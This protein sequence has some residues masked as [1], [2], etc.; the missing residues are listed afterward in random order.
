M[1]IWKKIS[2][3]FT[4]LTIRTEMEKAFVTTEY[5]LEEMS[6]SSWIAEYGENI[7]ESIL[8]NLSVSR[9]NILHNTTQ[10]PLYDNRGNYT[11]MER[12]QITEYIYWY[13][14][15]NEHLIKRLSQRIGL[16]V[17]KP[18]WRQI[19][20][21]KNL[22][23]AL[24]HI[25]ISAILGGSFLLTGYF[26]PYDYR[27]F[28]RTHSL[29]YE[30][31]ISAK[32]FLQRDTIFDP[33]IEADL[34]KWYNKIFHIHLSTISNATKY[35]DLSTDVRQGIISE[36]MT[37]DKEY[38]LVYLHFMDEIVLPQIRA[39][40]QEIRNEI[41]ITLDMDMGDA[42]F[43]K[44]TSLVLL[45]LVIFLSPIIIILVKNATTTIQNFA[46]VLVERTHQLKNEKNKSDRLLRQMLPSTVIRQLKQQRQVIAES[47]ESVT[48]FFSDIVGF[49]FISSNSSPMEVVSLLNQLY[50]LF[51]IRIQKY[52]VY[53]VETIGDAYMV[54]SGLPKKAPGHKHAS[55][56][57]FMSLDLITSVSSFYIPHR[58]FEKLQIRV[59]VNSGPCVAG[60]VGTSMP[61]YCLF[62]D[63]I[64]VASRME[65][66][67][68]AMKI[69][70]SA[71]TKELLDHHGGFMLEKRG[72]IEIKGK[73]DME[74]FWLLGHENMQSLGS[75]SPLDIDDILS[76][77]AY[78]PEFLQMI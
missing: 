47:F 46:N 33:Q 54:V 71:T 66:R 65:N 51:D 27:E 63:T 8:S 18:V 76:T 25:S 23:E 29:S 34:I 15:L 32:H 4:L 75:L 36:K 35:V 43:V 72:S 49:T 42:K 14:L 73:G 44:T 5:T 62:G 19:I 10:I 57:A 77:A 16:S 67:G 39:S 31:L 58:P 9:N 78:E 7:K 2:F 21:Y 1:I 50:R 11:N 45:L 69:H 40:Q 41:S 22:I 48:I 60:V 12:H 13:N 30:H 64:N 17:A 20:A 53:K 26:H 24:E 38:G 74:T 52:D 37:T 28:I 70:V 6:N 56:I 3:Y 55:E 61:R 59:G 68:E